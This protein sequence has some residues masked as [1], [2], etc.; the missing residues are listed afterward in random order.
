MGEGKK[1]FKETE[2]IYRFIKSE[3]ISSNNVYRHKQLKIVIC[4][5]KMTFPPRRFAH[6]RSFVLLWY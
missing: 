4:L 3:T 2:N 1:W 5:F 6:R